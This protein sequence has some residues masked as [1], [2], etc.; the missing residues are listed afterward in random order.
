MKRLNENSN[1]PKVQSKK[2]RIGE[3]IGRRNSLQ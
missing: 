3:L 1:K 2:S